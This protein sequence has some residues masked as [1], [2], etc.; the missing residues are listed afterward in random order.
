MLIIDTILIIYDH[1]IKQCKDFIANINIYILPTT[2]LWLLFIERGLIY[3]I[4][5]NV[6]TNRL[7]TQ[8][9][10][11]V[12]G[13]YTNY[14]QSPFWRH[15]L[16]FPHILIFLQVKQFI[17]QSFFLKHLMLKSQVYCYLADAFWII[18]L[19]LTKSSV[20]NKIDCPSADAVGNTLPTVLYDID[21]YL[22]T[23]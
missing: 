2:F 10:V 7:H 6:L 11:M 15:L 20:W 9:Q 14:R 16:Y 23:D 19:K 3:L 21:K 8:T 17:Y 22:W 5:T 12:L 1:N 4:C 18:V 13:L